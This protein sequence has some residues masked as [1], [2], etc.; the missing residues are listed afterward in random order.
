MT[1]CATSLLDLA[2]CYD[3]PHSVAMLMLDSFGLAGTLPP[4]VA[5]LTQLRALGLG[6]NPNLTG[7]VPPQLAGLSNLL[8]MSAEVCALGL[9]PR[10]CIHAGAGGHACMPRF[11]L[12][13][14]HSALQWPD[15]GFRRPRALH[16]AAH[17]PSTRLDDSTDFRLHRA[18]S[19][20]HPC[21]CVA[22]LPLARRTRA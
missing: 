22:A 21:G 13:R 20:W 3:E 16:G 17:V 7:G 19:I 9:A 1:C 2:P 12:R 10:A 8:W 6:N 5:G 15:W 18:S 14:R 4:L 11:C